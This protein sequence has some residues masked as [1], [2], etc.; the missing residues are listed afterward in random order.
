VAKHF[1]LLNPLGSILAL[2]GV[3]VYG[4]FEEKSNVEVGDFG[5]DVSFLKFDPE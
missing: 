5:F 3:E 2:W 1:D 4:Y